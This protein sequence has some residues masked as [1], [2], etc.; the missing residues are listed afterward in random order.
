M[1]WA[2]VKLLIK[3]Q[4]PPKYPQVNNSETIIKEHDKEMP[5]EIQTQLQMS[6]IKCLKKDIYL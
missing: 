6:M 1:I 2:V 3:S 5:K 4:K